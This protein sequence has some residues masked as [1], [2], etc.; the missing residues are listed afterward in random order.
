MNK[1]LG[2]IVNKEVTKEEKRELLHKLAHLML[3]ETKAQ[4]AWKVLLSE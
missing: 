4:D 2:N 3:Q 1:D